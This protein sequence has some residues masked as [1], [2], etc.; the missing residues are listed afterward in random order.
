MLKSLSLE[1][2]LLFTSVVSAY[3]SVLITS[4]VS[5]YLFQLFTL[6]LP[7]LLYFLLLFLSLTSSNSSI[8][9]FALKSFLVI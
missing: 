8:E 6:V 1:L 5:A 9:L 3:L 2:F 4:D 7:S